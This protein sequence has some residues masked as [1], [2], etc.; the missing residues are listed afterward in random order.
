MT[1]VIDEHELG[2]LTQPSDLR[3]QRSTQRRICGLTL[4]TVTTG[5]WLALL[6]NLTACIVA[7]K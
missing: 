4:P 2:Y 6:D 1:V 5:H 7:N 3:T